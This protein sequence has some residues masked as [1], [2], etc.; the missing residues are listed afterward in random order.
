MILVRGRQVLLAIVALLAV[1]LGFQPPARGAVLRVALDGSG[2]F[3]SVA[4]AALAAASGDSILVA[5]GHYADTHVQVPAGVA[6]AIIGDGDEGSVVLARGLHCRGDGLGRLLLEALVVDGGAP[7]IGLL[8]LSGLAEVRMYNV[9]CSRGGRSTSIVLCDTV[10]I[11]ACQ[12]LDNNN[13]WGVNGGGL[14]VTACRAVSILGTLFAG[15]RTTTGG[16]PDDYGGGGGGLWLNVTGGGS[17]SISGCTFVGNEAPN[18]SAAT[19]VGAAEV[20][21]NTIVRNRG[22]LSALYVVAAG[23]RVYANVMADNDGYGMLENGSTGRVICR[24]NAFWRNRGWPEGPYAHRDQWSGLCGL[25]P[26]GS[27]EEIWDDPKFCDLDGGRYGVTT[28]SPLLPENRGS[29]TG[30]CT[31]IVGAYGAECEDNP[32][33]V[34]PMTWGRVKARYGANV[35]DR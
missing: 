16:E 34:T 7:N 20:F 30:S 32:P 23:A 31:E 28:T 17:A 11:E 2:D 4:A 9:V 19:I 15:N 26:D 14:S 12:F 8:S 22:G 35:A 3:T 25:E 29:D 27:A 6:L 1:G 5:P 13:T 21:G 10:V 33:A 24:C 18:G